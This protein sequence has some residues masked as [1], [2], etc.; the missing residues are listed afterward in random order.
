MSEVIDLVRSQQDID[1]TALCMW[2][3]ARGE[4]M[5]GMD[6]VAWV[7][8]N[9]CLRRGTDPATEVMR[10]WQFSSMT[11]V[12]DP[13]LHLIPM[14][15]DPMHVY[16]AK[17]AEAILRGQGGDSLVGDATMYYSDTIP[18]PARW[19]RSKLVFVAKV[20]HHRFYIEK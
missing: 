11:A 10:P 19:D 5:R 2:R 7:V 15:G 9:R 8:R 1:L 13:Q 3:E 4:G 12:G 20:G 18:F 6:C 17:R 16:A 14:P